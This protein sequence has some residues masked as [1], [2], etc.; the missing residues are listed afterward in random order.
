MVVLAVTSDYPAWVTVAL[1]AVSVLHLLVTSWLFREQRQRGKGSPS[2]QPLGG[3]YLLYFAWALI[4]VPVAIIMA[5]GGDNP[6]W[7]QMVLGLPLAAP[8]VVQWL[9]QKRRNQR[10]AT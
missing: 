8:A 3:A 7:G 5:T 6:N 9:M 4:T 1:A 10:S 2:A